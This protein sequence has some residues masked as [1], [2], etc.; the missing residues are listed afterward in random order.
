VGIENRGGLTA[1]QLAVFNRHDGVE[2][3]LVIHGCVGR[4]ARTRSN[5]TWANDRLQGK[6]EIRK[7]NSEAMYHSILKVRLFPKY[8]SHVIVPSQLVI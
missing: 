1:L 2:Q 8:E 5:A 3:L 7:E 4:R 6:K